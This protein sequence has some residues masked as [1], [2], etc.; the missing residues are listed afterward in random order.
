MGTM[1]M[2]FPTKK[3]HSVSHGYA[4]LF[5]FD[6]WLNANT[7]ILYQSFEIDVTWGRKKGD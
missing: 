3:K 5:F 6:M 1:W 2:R 7:S 4:I